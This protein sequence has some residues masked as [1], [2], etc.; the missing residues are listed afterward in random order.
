MSFWR[1]L[2]AIQDDTDVRLILP[3]G[4]DVRLGAVVGVDRDGNFTLQG[5]AK[6]LLGL[7][8]GKAR[9]GKPGDDFLRTSGKDTTYQFRAAGAGSALFPDL[10]KASAGFDVKL[11]SA[12]SWLLA[13]SGRR[14]DSLD[15]LNRFRE[16]ILSAYARGVWKPDWALVT[17]VASAAR[18]T[19]LA[20]RAKDTNVAVS[21]AASVTPGMLADVQITTG[22]SVRA[23][24]RDVIQWLTDRRTPVGV[25]AVRVRDPWWRR[26]GVGSL[27]KRAE[28][29]WRGASDEDFWE[30][31]AA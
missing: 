6:S 23:T 10:P 26:P 21:V 31:L 3:F 28:V 4:L 2:K 30:D 12:K 8:A 29:D 25:T 5:S 16:P 22:A 17:G 14:L 9:A 7:R 13:L 19:L 27:S 1:Q 11:S 15:E 20:A 24:S 18:M